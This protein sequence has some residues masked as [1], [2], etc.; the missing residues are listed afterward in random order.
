MLED[1]ISI[2]AETVKNVPLETR[3]SLY[4]KINWQSRALCIRGARGVGKTTMLLQYYH[5][6]YGH[7]DKCLYISADNLHVIAKGLYDITREYFKYGGEA[8]IIDEIHKY[9]GWA[10]ELKNIL[11]TYRS[12]QVLISGSSSLNLLKGRND[13]SRRLVY[14]ELKGL[15]FR[16]FIQFD[17]KQEFKPVQFRDLLLKHVRLAS[18]ITARM[19]ILKSFRDYLEYG[20]YPFFLEDKRDYMQKVLNIIEKTIFEDIAA[21]FN[22]SPPKI[23][24]L[25][26]LLWLIATSSP[27]T[28]NIDR[29]SRDL[30]ISREYVYHYIE[31]L[32]Q[33]GLIVNLRKAVRGSA[34]VRK[35]GK[36]FMENPSLLKATA[37]QIRGKAEHGTVG[38]TF[39]ACQIAP[40]LELGLHDK[41]D[42]IVDGKYV[43]EVGGSSKRPAK[44]D[45]SDLITAVD[46]VEIG[47]GKRIPL[48]LFGFLY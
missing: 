42:F 43:I 17:E 26:K 27:F 34:L 32:E 9:P 3:R 20:Y 13:L 4:Q 10:L 31:Y 25:K 5:E 30:A 11:D 7:P 47:A 18:D 23:P 39:F 44:Y 41:A 15:S 22:V 2:H 24:V 48:Y 12:K 38:E 6:K 29:L 16:E 8:V 35:P 21:V 40:V 46:N 36:I 45:I 37:G 19:T 14:Y 28:P 33:A 1:I